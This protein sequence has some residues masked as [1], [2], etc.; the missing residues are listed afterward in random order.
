MGHPT[1]LW[2]PKGIVLSIILATSA[3]PAGFS[4]LAGKRAQVSEWKS[5]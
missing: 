3:R 5:V 2:M 1:V 4:L